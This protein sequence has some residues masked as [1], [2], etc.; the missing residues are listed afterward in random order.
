MVFLVSFFQFWVRDMG[1]DLRGRDRGM[2]E[3]FLDDTDIST[4]GEECR[5]ETMSKR[6]GVHIFQYP[7]LESVGLHHI[8]DKKS[9]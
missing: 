9:C 5:R 3:K 2:T 4:V 6:M 7:C 1:I 8:G